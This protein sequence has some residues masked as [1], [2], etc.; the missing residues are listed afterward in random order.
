LQSR[1]HRLCLWHSWK[2]WAES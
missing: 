1:P 2:S